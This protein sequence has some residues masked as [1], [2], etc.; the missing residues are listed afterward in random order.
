MSFTPFFP[1]WRSRFNRGPR[2]LF[3]AGL[4]GL[5]RCTLDKWEERFVP[6]LAGLPELTAAGASA[7]ERPYSPR[8]TWWCFLWQMI[9]C[10]CSC[11]EVVR[12]LQAMLV[13]EG[14]PT[15]DGNTSG[16]CQARA[17]LP[18][19]LLLAAMAASAKAADKRVSPSEA[20]QG[21]V[22]K[23]LDGT[24]LTLPDTEENQKEYPQPSSQM[25]GCGFP[26][27]Q[28]LVV[29]SA[30]GAVVLDYVK[31]NH[32]HGEMR[33]LN[34]VCPT[35]KRQDIIVYDRAAGNYVACAQLR[36]QGVR[37]HQPGRLSENRLA[38]GQKN[39]S[40]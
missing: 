21:R 29:W 40:Q 18:E 1:A 16:Y 23:V 33:L 25:P 34:Q 22:I 24:T 12:Q 26:Q 27:M 6:L 19:A 32:H 30:R 14:R 37:S 7:R 13:L 28:L 17:R 36:A 8:R 10:N 39:R 20:L 15:V 38:P 3:S 9:R 2:T 31:G 5:R 11:E 35:F 4:D